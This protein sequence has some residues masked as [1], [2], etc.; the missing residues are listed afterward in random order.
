MAEGERRRK[1]RRIDRCLE[2]LLLNESINT[3][4]CDLSIL[5]PN[6]MT[7]H[8]VETSNSKEPIAI[9]VMNSVEH[10]DSEII[11]LASVD[12]DAFNDMIENEFDNFSPDEYPNNL[13]IEANDGGDPAVQNT[14]AE[15]LLQYDMLFNVPRGQM[16]YLLKL[17]SKHGID[18]PKSVY[19][20]RKMS[21]V[22]PRPS[23]E[24]SCGEYTYLS[25]QRCME[26][27]LEDGFLSIHRPDK[28]NRFITIDATLN[29]DGLPLFRSSAVSI[30]PILI[31]F[32]SARQPYP[33]ALY[34]G[35]QKPDLTYLE[36]LVNEVKSL[37]ENGLVFNG[38]TVRLGEIKFVC[39]APARAHFQGIL[40]HTAKRGCGYC[41]AEGEYAFDRVIFPDHV[42]EPRTDETYAKMEENNQKCR[43]PL[44]DIVGLKSH[45]PVDEQHSIC[46]GVFRKMCFLYFSK[47][48][49]NTLRGKVS[50][51]ALSNLSDEI[52]KYRSCTPSEFQRQIRRLD[53]ELVHYK[54][55]EYR[56]LLLYF[57]PFLFKKYL[58]D[59][60]LQHFLLL[61]FSY[62]VFSSDRHEDKYEHAQRSIEIFVKRFGTIFGKQSMSYNV[63]ILL[64]IYD[65]VKRFG[66][67]KRFSTF[68]FENYLGLIK[69]RVRNTR[70]VY[71]HV[72]RQLQFV[73]KYN[74]SLNSSDLN[75]TVAKP[76]NCAF[77]G[78]H[79]ILIDKIFPDGSVSGFILQFREDLY[80]YPYASR[81]LDIGYYALSRKRLTGKPSNKAI[82]FTVEDSGLVVFPLA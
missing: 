79:C 78:R 76:N 72:L 19:H 7:E 26:K 24:I 13:E 21:R 58:S 45:F 80:T 9:K 52:S 69:R 55:T 28:T 27:S 37:R 73:N 30:W 15:D 63:H 20:L 23:D 50:A 77:V 71:Q 39:D 74:K 25:I 59:E 67:L 70:F 3:E 66:P 60:T 68:P 51:T 5:E 36:D 75:F 16:E 31:S 10:S 64:H 65:Y 49:G 33:V 4:G 1:N 48:K 34:Y 22:L 38:V 8:D 47:I 12:D 56:S 17:M 46:L 54:A 41:R 62:Y 57:G 11:S 42:G 40:G 35:I 6:S 61:H 18:V 29:I 2:N 53:T 43:S 44:V 82:A 81:V 32:G 14:L